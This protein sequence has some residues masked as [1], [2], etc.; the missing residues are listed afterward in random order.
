MNVKNEIFP[1]GITLDV[2]GMTCSNC[3]LRIEKGLKKVPGVRDARVNFAMETAKVEFKS[4]IEIERLLDKI[5]SLGYR[6]FVHENL[7]IRGE[8]E[9]AHEKEF[10]NLKVRVFI[11]ALL[12]FP[13]VSGMVGHIANNQIFEYFSFIINHWLQFAPATPIQFWIGA[14]EQKVIFRNRTVNYLIMTSPSS[15]RR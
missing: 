12:S 8:A 6:A 1:D 15:K 2:I 9:K 14:P 13:M 5:D 10:K 4:S 11:S 3:A 7:E